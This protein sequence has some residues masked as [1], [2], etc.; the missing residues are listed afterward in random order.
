MVG[1]RVG[2]VQL[3]NIL[4]NTAGAVVT[5]LVLLQWLGTAS[6]LRLIGSGSLG[7]VL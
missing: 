4:G 3:C 2:L 6:A 5:G 1:R 7:F